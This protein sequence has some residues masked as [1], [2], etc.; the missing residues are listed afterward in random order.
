M[1]KGAKQMKR[2][3]RS[4]AITMGILM[5]ALLLGL[6]EGLSAVE[7]WD[8]ESTRGYQENVSGIE[9]G[10]SSAWADEGE[11]GY[12]EEPYEEQYSEEPEEKGGLYE[13]EPSDLERESAPHWQWPSDE[14]DLP[15]VQ[16]SDDDTA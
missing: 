6:P 12:E 5:L 14:E 2:K 11:E 10:E 3:E 9:S 13:E 8:T 4:V 7:A 16:P 1:V 15:P